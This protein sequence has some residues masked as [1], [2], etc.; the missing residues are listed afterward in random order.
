M[1]PFSEYQHLEGEPLTDRDKKQVG[2][3]FWGRGKWDHFVLPHLPKNCKGLSIVDMGCN[4][5]LF[6]K[7]AQEI[8]F[9]KGIGIDGNL[10]SVTRGMNLKGRK[11]YTIRHSDMKN[12]IED[13]P[14]VDYTLLV[15][16]HYYFNM[17]DWVT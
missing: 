17:I 4:A 3:K 2:S 10:E 16:A 7:F 12:C 1:K 11:N 13:L 6:L 14:I 9:S 15:N 5:G 8:G